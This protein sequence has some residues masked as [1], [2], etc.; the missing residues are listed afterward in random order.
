MT[1]EAAFLVPVILLV[2]A[3]MLQPAILLFDRAVMES[4]AGQAI[5]MLSTRPSGAPDSGY[6]K[7]VEDQLSAIPDIDIFHVVG[8]GWDIELEGDEMSENVKVKIET[9]VLPLPLV[10]MAASMVWD[11]D[12]DGYLEVVVERAADTQPGWVWKQGG[13][14]SDWI[15]QW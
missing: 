15:G 4:A 6:E 9:D 3:I 2:L 8:S 12:N 1:V 11:S 14:P 10:G 5:R 7:V 13:G